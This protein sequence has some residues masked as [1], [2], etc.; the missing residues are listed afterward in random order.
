[1]TT[2]NY[3]SGSYAWRLQTTQLFRDPAAWYHL[4]F[5]S[6]TTNAISSE[7]LRIYVNGQRETSFSTESYPSL[8]YADANFGWNTT[9][10]DQ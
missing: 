5:V 10:H 2:Y 1:M 3:V 4:V 7:R 8:S 6:D 9:E